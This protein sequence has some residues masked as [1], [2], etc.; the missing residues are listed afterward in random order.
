MMSGGMAFSLYTPGD[1]FW[2][3]LSGA[4]ESLDVG[5]TTLVDAAHMTYSIEHC[6]QAASALESSGVRATYC[7]APSM[8]F[9]QFSPTLEREPEMIPSWWD[10]MYSTLAE[11]L[12]SGSGRVR[13]GI[14][15]DS[16]F[17]GKDTTVDFIKKARKAGAKIVT[18]HSAACMTPPTSPQRSFC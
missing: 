14:G 16:Y 17:L 10:S 15:Y 7:P 13:L 4:L 6:L 1:V 5:T 2:G 18:S 9:K 11:R 3:E 12:R 8:R